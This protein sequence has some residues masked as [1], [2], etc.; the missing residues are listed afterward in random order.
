MGSKEPMKQPQILRVVFDTNT[1][2]STLL[3]RNGRLAWLRMH[4]AERRCVP[5]LSRATAAELARVLGY[6]KFKLTADRRLELL[7]FYLPYCETVQVAGFCPAI[8]RDAQD[9]IFLDLA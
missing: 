8:C 5:L 2:L 1:V 7:G 4:W 6:A 9:Q 3:F